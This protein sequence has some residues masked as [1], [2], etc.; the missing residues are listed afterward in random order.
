MW[1]HLGQSIQVPDLPD[2]GDRGN[3]LVAL[4][5]FP[6]ELPELRVSSRKQTALQLYSQPLFINKFSYENIRL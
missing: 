5:S 2:A 3:I 1:V 6:E 4:L